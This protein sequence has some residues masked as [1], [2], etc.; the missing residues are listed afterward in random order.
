MFPFG[1]IAA[2]EP[3]PT[4]AVPEERQQPTL[5]IEK[6]ENGYVVRTQFCN[7]PYVFTDIEDALTHMCEVFGE[8]VD[9]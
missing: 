1:K 8:T 4:L 9:Y 6:A 3:Q 7:K 2:S 5:I